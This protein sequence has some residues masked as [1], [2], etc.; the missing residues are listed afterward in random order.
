MGKVLTGIRVTAR[1]PLEKT[2]GCFM[3]ERKFRQ[4]CEKERRVLRSWYWIISRTQ[5]SGS[6]EKIPVERAV[7]GLLEAERAEE[8]SD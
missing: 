3:E 4:V 1:K 6:L 8:R 7:W 5:T 2:R